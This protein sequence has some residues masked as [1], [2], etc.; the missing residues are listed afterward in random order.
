MPTGQRITRQ[1]LSLAPQHL[2]PNRQPSLTTICSPS[3][4]GVE[5]AQNPVQ[6]P[7]AGL[8]GA[9]QDPIDMGAGK[10]GGPERNPA[11]YDDLRPLADPCNAVVSLFCT[12]TSGEGGIR[13]D[14]PNAKDTNELGD[15]EIGS[16]ATGAAIWPEFT[17]PDPDLTEVVSRWPALPQAV[18]GQVLA[19]VRGAHLPA[20]SPACAA[21][22]LPGD[23][24]A[25]PAPAQSMPAAP[26][27]SRGSAGSR[28]DSGVVSVPG[29]GA[30][31]PGCGCTGHKG[32]SGT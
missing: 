6:Q 15:S 14:S 30:G 2:R 21:V 5:A 7:A 32:V 25:A 10:Q 16:A 28:G 17:W 20:D 4:Q 3:R 27:G 11:A 1:A 31:L 12:S 26:T 23:C 13:E 18:R 24:L 19:L 29:L 9:S 8:R 22:A